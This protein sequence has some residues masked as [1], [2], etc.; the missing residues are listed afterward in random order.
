[1]QETLEVTQSFLLVCNGKC[2]WLWWHTCDIRPVG[3]GQPVLIYVS[4]HV[5]YE[6]LLLRVHVSS[7]NG[8]VSTSHGDLEDYL[9]IWYVFCRGLVALHHLLV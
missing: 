6:P 2:G 7:G 9:Q 5:V 1:M 4:I 8:R 3:N